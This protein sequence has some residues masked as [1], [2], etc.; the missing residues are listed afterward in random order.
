MKNKD[1]LSEK[2]GN[3]LLAEMSL[4]DAISH[5]S[6]GTILFRGDPARARF[7]Q[8]RIWEAGYSCLEYVW[9]LC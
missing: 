6:G 1:G 5:Y 8:A 4:D 7:L 2:I 9:Y 3:L